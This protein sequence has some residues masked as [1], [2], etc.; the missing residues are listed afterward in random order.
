MLQGINVT[1]VRGDRELFKNINFSLEVGGLLQVHGPNGSGKTSLLRMMCGLSL[2]YVSRV[3]WPD[4][5]SV[6][7]MQVR[8]LI[9]SA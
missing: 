6:L 7:M 1:C 5:K 8:Y 9:P 3:Q 4:L 2:T